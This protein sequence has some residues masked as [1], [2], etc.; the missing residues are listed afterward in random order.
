MRYKIEDYPFEKYDCLHYLKTLYKDRGLKLF[1]QFLNRTQ[2]RPFSRALINTYAPHGI[3]LEVGVGARTICPTERTILSDAFFAHGLHD[4]IAKVFFHGDEIPYEN[5]SFC[6][7]VSEHVLEHVANPLKVLKE[8]IRTLRPGGKLFLFL[9]HKERTNDSHR[10]VTTLEHVIDDY[11]KDVPLDDQTHMDEWF[12]NVVRKGLM[13]FHYSHLSTK[14]LLKTGSI[15]HHVWTEK[16]ILEIVQFC[17]LKVR[18]VNA[19]VPDRRDSFV[20]VSE[21]S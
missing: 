7:I 17:G 11:N 6:F 2:R 21:K 4:S 5:D 3:G 8:C 15:H 14:D 13:P 10:Q 1:Y 9:P 16:E 12:K 18:Y 19:K 20:V